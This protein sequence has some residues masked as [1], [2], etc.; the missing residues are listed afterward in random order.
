MKR[1]LRRR[2]LAGYALFEALISVLVASVGIIG[3]ARLQTVGLKMNTSSQLRQRAVVLG[4]QMTDRIRANPAATDLTAGPPLDGYNNPAIGSA[5]CLTS[6]CTP[7]TL[8]VADMTEWSSDVAAQLPNG[9]GTVCRDSSVLSITGAPA[10]DGAGNLIVVQI[11]WT[12]TDG[13]TTRF[14]TVVQP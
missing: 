2:T 9:T 14:N 13:T 1:P 12:D 3:A 7:A 5:A 10:C 11:A 8:A 4:Y 6:G